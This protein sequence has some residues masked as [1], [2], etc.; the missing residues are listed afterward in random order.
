MEDSWIGKQHFNAHGSEV[1][2]DI[3]K[4]NYVQFVLQLE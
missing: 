1:P 3:D 2:E 4:N